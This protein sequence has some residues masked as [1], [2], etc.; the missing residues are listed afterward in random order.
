M[1]QKFDW[2]YA[3]KIRSK[4]TYEYLLSVY[5]KPLSEDEFVKQ[6]SELPRNKA[7]ASK[8]RSPSSA[9]QN[10]RNLKYKFGFFQPKE[11]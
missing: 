11:A 7:H 9:R 3:K 2:E 10:Y 5:D 1:Y 8:T 4:E 6:Y